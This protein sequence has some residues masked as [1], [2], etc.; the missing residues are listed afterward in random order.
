MSP[1]RAVYQAY[2]P[3]SYIGQLPPH[4]PPLGN[5]LQSPAPP[6][7]RSTIRPRMYRNEEV[8]L[9]RTPSDAS[10]LVLFNLP[11]RPFVHPYYDLKTVAKARAD[12]NEALRREKEDTAAAISSHVDPVSVSSTT[13]PASKVGFVAASLSASN[14][15]ASYHALHLLNL[16]RVLHSLSKKYGLV[17][18]L[19]VQCKPRE[20]DS[21]VVH[22][23]KRRR[24]LFSMNDGM[25]DE[26]DEGSLG[27]QLIEEFESGFNLWAYVKYYSTLHATVAMKEIGRTHLIAGERLKAQFIKRNAHQSPTKAPHPLSNTS[28]TTHTTNAASIPAVP[29]TSHHWYPLSHHRCLELCNYFLG[30]NNWNCEI[31]S[32]RPYD[33]VNDAE[34]MDDSLR[35]SSMFHAS[36]A[37]KFIHSWTA[38]VLVDMAGQQYV[39]SGVGHALKGEMSGDAKKRAVTNAYRQLFASLALIILKNGKVA[40]AILP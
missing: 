5:S 16:E 32:I 31:R 33:S 12:A 40:L 24:P 13:T 4:P 10:H 3:P 28:G 25:L 7:P 35:T 38:T 34:L 2:Q 36:A 26:S 23:H 37:D 8:L 1:E 11:S 15:C 29:A 17:H 27:C 6:S 14:L 19:S 22:V 30:F 21:D 18:E 39:C 20:V 9:F